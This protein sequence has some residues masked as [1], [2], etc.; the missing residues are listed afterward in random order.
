M[1]TTQRVMIVAICVWLLA[2]VTAAAFYNPQ[3][4]RWLNRDPIE[5]KGAGLI[6]DNADSQVYRARHARRSEGVNASAS[7]VN[8]P[9]GCVDTDGRV[10]ACA[11]LE[12]V[13]GLPEIPAL[14]PALVVAGDCILIGGVAIGGYC[15]GDRLGENLG[16]HDFAGDWIGTGISTISRACR[17]YTCRTR[18]WVVQVNNDNNV[19]GRVIG[20][21]AGL[22]RSGA[23]KAALHHAASQ[24]APGT[25]TKHCSPCECTR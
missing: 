11:G 6:S 16:I 24:T 1:K 14:A 2:T 17:G 19:V 10:A 18:C 3:S 7:L 25:R 5:E 20:V 15:A 13:V 8:N 12:V 9:I 22:T 23:C 4:G 21:G